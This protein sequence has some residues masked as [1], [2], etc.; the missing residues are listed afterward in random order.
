MSKKIYQEGNIPYAPGDK[1]S[2]NEH[3]FRVLESPYGLM[4]GETYTVE[5]L[6]WEKQNSPRYGYLI[7]L[8]KH[9]GKERIFDAVW[10]MFTAFSVAGGH[11]MEEPDMTLD[12]IHQAQ[13]IFNN[14]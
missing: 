7:H 4:L 14:G 5:K 3:G 9:R 10:E 1:I 8:Q 11:A 13:E 12:E 2:L 6:E